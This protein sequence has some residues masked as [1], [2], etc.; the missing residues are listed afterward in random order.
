MKLEVDW[1]H[2]SNWA[3]SKRCVSP[4]F[5]SDCHRSIHQSV[6]SMQLLLKG[7]HTLKMAGIIFERKKNQKFFKQEPWK[8]SKCYPTEIVSSKITPREER[9]L[10]A[11]L[12]GKNEC[13]STTPKILQSPGTLF[14][15]LR[16][17]RRN[18]NRTKAV[19][20]G[21]RVCSCCPY[22]D[23]STYFAAQMFSKPL[24]A[25]LSI[26]H[27]CILAKDAGLFFSPSPN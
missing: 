8:N 1:G 21:W 22:S 14:P 17:K 4:S 19:W 12:E 3:S 2:H 16:V 24:S 10:I 18:M 7:L 13:V 26:F 9:K 25:A 23:T 5:E 6:G 11:L 27:P 15:I 20:K